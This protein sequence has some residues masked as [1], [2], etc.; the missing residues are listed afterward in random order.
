MDIKKV[1]MMVGATAVGVALGFMLY[2]AI[3]KQMGTSTDK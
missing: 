2:N 3:S 1:G